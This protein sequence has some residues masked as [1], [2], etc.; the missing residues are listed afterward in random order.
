MSKWHWLTAG[1]GAVVVACVLASCSST[2][3]VGSRVDN[4][5][6]FYNTFY[7]AEEDFA[8]GMESVEA[9][10]YALD[11]NRFASIF[12]DP[13]GGV[14]EAAF[15][16]AID[17]SADVLREHPQSKW[18]DDALMLIG[19]SY[20]Y[21]SEFGAAA[22]KFNEIIAL[23][24]ERADEA[25][26]WLARTLVSQ[27]DA[28]RAAEHVRLSLERD[29]VQDPWRSQ[30]WLVAAELRT[31]QAVWPEALAALDHALQGGLDRKEET[32]AQLLRGQ[33]FEKRSDYAAAVRAYR[34]ATESREFE[35]A[36]AGEMGALRA[37]AQ[38]S[39]D[40]D[41]VEQADLLARDDRNLE[42]RD[43]LRLLE[44][45]L[46][47]L[48][49][50]PAE[51]RQSY[52]ELL[53]GEEPI[54][55]D[56]QSRAY[57]QMAVMY[58]DVWQDYGKAAAY[59]D[60][61]ATTAS[62]PD[63]QEQRYP[64]PSTTLPDVQDLA[65]RYGAVAEQQERVARYDSLLALGSLPEEAFQQRIQEIAEAKREAEAEANEREDPDAE[66]D[67]FART[68]RRPGMQGQ[69]ERTPASTIAAEAAN[70]EAGFLFHRS[71]QRVQEGRR[72]FQQRWGARPREPFWR[73]TDITPDADQAQAPTV[74][75]AGQIESTEGAE[76]PSAEEDSPSGAAA[77]DGEPLV[78]VE[79][80]PRTEAEQEAMREERTWAWYELGNALFLN[81]AQP[82]SAL[83]WYERV[84]V[85]AANHPVYERAVYARA[86]ALEAAGQPNAADGQYESLIQANPDSPFANR[87]R[88]RLGRPV[89][90][91]PDSTHQAFEAYK[92]ARSLVEE[93]QWGAGLE[94]LTEVARTYRTDIVVAPRALWSM[95]QA[96]LSWHRRDST[97]AQQALRRAVDTLSFDEQG[98]NTMTTPD[99][100]AASR[101]EPAQQAGPPQVTAPGAATDTTRGAAEETAENHPAL[102]KL[103]QHLQSSFPDAP[104]SQ[105]A[106]RLAE[107]LSGED[108]TD[109]PEAE[110]RHNAPTT[111]SA[112]ER[113]LPTPRSSSED[114]V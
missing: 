6:A 103:L 81:I 4:F 55:R 102:R 34:A 70:E 31:E 75:D 62:R 35:V 43:A 99:D 45:Y 48:Q 92:E 47:V 104:H 68:A 2:S 90:T 110:S 39:T 85:E 65:E 28:E 111:R 29:D 94:R 56:L 15:E 79:A 8:R 59:F 40:P 114:G 36:L 46:H 37:Q 58:R 82:D 71:P 17:R 87:A 11:P 100:E 97:A 27:G 10:S 42:Q 109:S 21:T 60:S 3:M 66:D 89:S 50:R 84:L 67:G 25:R 63:N 14:D 32:R 69:D 108:P 83:A 86:E 107:A 112:P 30:L 54:G 5:R 9:Q 38:T 64:E 41:L 93:E 88:A 1:I 22:E 101:N 113:A 105:R 72:S 19:Q 20:F 52:Q 76:A 96:Y 49:Q 26:F 16:S 78:D 18:V 73:I 44:A 33:I 57:Y 95:G 91:S 106:A 7:N 24:N 77:S 53:H 98:A 51:A 12:P 74:T 13:S 23:G 61:S 80:V